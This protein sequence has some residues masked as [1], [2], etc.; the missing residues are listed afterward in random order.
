VV[1]DKQSLPQH[2]EGKKNTT[3]SAIWNTSEG[4]RHSFR[5]WLTPGKEDTVS[6]DKRDPGHLKRE[7]E[8]MRL[9][10]INIEGLQ[11]KL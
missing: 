5:S 4:R 7:A 8:T 1:S 9:C 11:S 10:F 2:P 6:K 3:V